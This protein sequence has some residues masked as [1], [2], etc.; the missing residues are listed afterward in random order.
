MPSPTA[1]GSYPTMPAAVAFL[2][3][4]AAFDE[5]LQ[6]RLQKKFQARPSLTL[7]SPHLF[8]SRARIALSSRD[9]S[10][11]ST[12]SR[13]GRG[14]G[15]GGARGPGRPNVPWDTGDEPDARPSELFPVSTPTA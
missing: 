15:R 5:S 3:R 10:S 13:G 11:A 6:H 7:H 8:V 12:M 14:G 9:T 1:L 2:G 4:L